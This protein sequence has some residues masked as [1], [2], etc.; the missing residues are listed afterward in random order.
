MP[1]LP[2][3]YNY[4]A[5]FDKGRAIELAALVDAAYQQLTDFQNHRLWPVPSSYTVTAKTYQ[6]TPPEPV[7]PPKVY[8]IEAQFYAVET[9]GLPSIVPKSA[10]PFGFVATHGTDVYVAIRGT[11]TTLEWVDDATVGFV[12]FFADPAN[13]A[14]TWGNTTKGFY[15][16]YAQIIPSIFTAIQNL[17]NAGIKSFSLFISGHS[18]GAALAH[19]T[20]AGIRQRL[21]L[22]PIVY[23]F[24]G[25]RTGDPAFAKAYNASG[26]QTWRIYNTEDIVPVLPISTNQLGSSSPTSIFVNVL[27]KG[28]PAGFV[29]IG[30]PVAVT[31]DQGVVDSNHNLDNLWATL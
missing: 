28:L 15:G 19:L 26:L 29:H 25:P 9:W 31:F 16:L 3:P 6:V 27:I 7:P 2:P 13:L 4:P 23:T 17:L 5:S 11:Q 24:S 22:D 10:L 21:G 14:V 1:A 8:Q 12:P 30:Y 18:L 20:A